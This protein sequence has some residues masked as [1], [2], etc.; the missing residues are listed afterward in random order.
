MK[1]LDLALAEGESCVTGLDCVQG[2][3]CVMPLKG[4]KRREIEPLPYAGFCEKIP[5]GNG[6]RMEFL[7]LNNS[8]YTTCMKLC[9]YMSVWQK[10]IIILYWFVYMVYFHVF[11]VS[12]NSLHGK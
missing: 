7:L 1:C 3:C 11:V 10:S 4:R 8:Q 9:L 6:Q 12:R 2:E 5:I